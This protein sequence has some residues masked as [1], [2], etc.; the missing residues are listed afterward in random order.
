MVPKKRDKN[1][2]DYIAE[3]CMQTDN[4]FA[5]PIELSS[6]VHANFI[7]RLQNDIHF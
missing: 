2:P 4:P 3:K 5:S 1:A 7:L 6:D